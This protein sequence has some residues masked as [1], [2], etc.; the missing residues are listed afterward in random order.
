M[1]VASTHCIITHPYFGHT[2]KQNLYKINETLLKMASIE[3]VLIL[4]LKI[5]YHLVVL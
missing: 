5:V 2:R 4:P 1:F 3:C